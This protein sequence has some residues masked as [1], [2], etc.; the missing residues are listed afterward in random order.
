MATPQEA[1]FDFLG[2]RYGLMRE[3]NGH[4]QVKSRERKDMLAG[5]APPP[6]PSRA[7]VFGQRVP[8]TPF[9]A[10]MQDF[11]LNPVTSPVEAGAMGRRF[12]AADLRI[13]RIP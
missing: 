5:I 4:Y 11:L 9:G 8:L 12:G 1:S 7:P 10:Q 2:M 3:A 13:Q 6:S